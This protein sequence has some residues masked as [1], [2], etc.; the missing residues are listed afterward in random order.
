MIISNDQTPRE[1]PDLNM[2]FFCLRAASGLFDNSF[3]QL[4]A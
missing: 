2:D 3:N 1:F 4:C